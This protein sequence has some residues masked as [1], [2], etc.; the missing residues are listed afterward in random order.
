MSVQKLT[1]AQNTLLVIKSRLSF[2]DDFTNDE[3]LKI[4][5][6]VEFKK[7]KKGEF[8]FEQSEKSKE[9]YYVINGSVDVFLGV[10]KKSSYSISYENHVHLATL[11]KRAIFGEM[12][13]ITGEPRSARVVS[14][15]DDT[16][17]LKF[18][19]DDIPRKD[20]KVIIAILYQKFVEI[21][22]EKLKTTTKKIYSEN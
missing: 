17:L 20:N 2:F 4:T 21:L 18:G 13:A 8:V 14:C 9:I 6:D 12:S 7:Y 16:S 10:Q 3:V 11:S 1:N 15:E 22:S 5:K 19:I